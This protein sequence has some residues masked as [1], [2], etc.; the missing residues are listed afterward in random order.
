VFGGWDQDNRY[1]S[2]AARPGGAPHMA[3]SSPFRRAY[4]E[5]RESQLNLVRRI[6][7][8]R[9]EAEASKYKAVP[10]PPKTGGSFLGDVAAPLLGGIARG[11]LGSLSGLGAASSASS[12]LS[13]GVPWSFPSGLSSSGILGGLGQSQFSYSPSAFNSTGFSFPR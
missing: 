3:G 11:V 4:D 2:V 13:S 12:P 8:S 5:Q 9:A 6:S 10:E 1:G 7:A